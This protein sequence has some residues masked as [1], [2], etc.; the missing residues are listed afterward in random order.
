MEDI[1][2]VKIWTEEE[3]EEIWKR[4]LNGESVS[5]LS[6]AYGKSAGSIKGVIRRRKEKEGKVTQSL[7]IL[8]GTQESE[9]EASVDIEEVER[10][11]EI[12]EIEAANDDEAVDDI[13]ETE[14]SLAAEEEADPD[15]DYPWFATTRIRTS[16]GRPRFKE[17]GRYYTGIAFRMRKRR[18]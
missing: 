17:H 16:F 3:K 12:E 14:E 6:E 7:D 2:T 18:R 9:T 8:P 5:E 1:N 13:G 4:Y 11:E 10:T 15:E